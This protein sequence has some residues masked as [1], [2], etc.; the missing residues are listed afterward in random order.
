MTH[1]DSLLSSLCAYNHNIYLYFY[2]QYM[3]LKYKR[4]LEG[5]RNGIYILLSIIL[6]SLNNTCGNPS[7]S[8]IHWVKFAFSHV[9]I[10]YHSVEYFA[11]STIHS[12][13]D[14]PKYPQ[15]TAGY[16]T[17]VD[18]KICNCSS[19]SYKWDGTADPLYLWVQHSQV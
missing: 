1:T 16:Q 6:F 15:G 17:S 11:C 12:I 2:I 14:V 13:T 7:K 19:L 8:T 18:T 5:F 9:C 3:Q 4:D 10:I